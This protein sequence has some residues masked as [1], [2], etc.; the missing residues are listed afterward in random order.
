MRFDPGEWLPLIGVL[1]IAGTTVVAIA[2]AW[3]HGRMRGMR[4]G[5]RDSSRDGDT[6]ARIERMER[7]LQAVAEE[8]ERL[9]EVQRFALKVISDRALSA[10]EKKQLPHGRVITPH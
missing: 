5:L 6:H 2:G 4:E 8:V 1:M 3:A 10:E 9:G 7:S